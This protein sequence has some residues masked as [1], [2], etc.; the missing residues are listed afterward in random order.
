MALHSLYCADVP[1]EKDTLNIR[2]ER[3]ISH[4]WHFVMCYFWR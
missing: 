2:C 1:Q 3:Y 4:C